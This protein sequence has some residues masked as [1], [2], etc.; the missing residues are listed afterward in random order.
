MLKPLRGLFSR[1]TATAKGNDALTA[2][3]KKFEK[4]CVVSNTRLA[5]KTAKGT[6]LLE[7]A[8]TD[9]L[10]GYMIEYNASPVTA[11]GVMGCAFV[12]GCKLPGNT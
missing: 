7:V 3:M 4:S 6:L 12:A 9:G 11:V 8:C 1:D 10:K 2:D 5:A